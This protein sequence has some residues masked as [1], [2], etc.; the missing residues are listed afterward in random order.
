VLLALRTTREMRHAQEALTSMH[1]RARRAEE[2][3]QRDPLT[4]LANRARFD[5]FYAETFSIAMSL[6]V[7]LSVLLIDIDRFK[8]INDTRGHAAGDK[9]LVA[10]AKLLGAR[11]RPR[12][13]AA[14]YGGEEFVLVLPETN[15]S[16]AA[17]VAERVRANVEAAEVALDGGPLKVT[18]SVG[19]AT[20]FPALFESKE[21]LLRAADVALYAAKDAGRN[22]VVDAHALPSGDDR[23]PLRASSPRP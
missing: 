4:A 18:I 13:L 5:A 6:G 1:A 22:R 20:L 16:G 12:D 23:L 8:R 2:D 21:A 9:V 10:V 19:H 7:P 14:R 3:S 15:G 17:V 11:L